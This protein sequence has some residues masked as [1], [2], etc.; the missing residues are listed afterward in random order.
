NHYNQTRVEYYRQLEHASRSG[1]DVLPFI[2]YAVE[3]FVDGLKSQIEFVQD[4][5]LDDAWRTY[6][7]LAFKDKS[8]AA[9][10]RRRRLALDLT[11][12]RTAVPLKNL[13]QISPRVAALYSTK[14]Y[15]T[16]SRDVAE[17]LRM[18]LI[19]ETPDG[20]RPSRDTIPPL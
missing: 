5:Q 20:Y 7:Y 16:L 4:R 12:Q 9:N 19:E 13:N 2:T 17:L 14:S 3:G 11:A 6:I 1:G 18:G 8:G 15:K 10:E